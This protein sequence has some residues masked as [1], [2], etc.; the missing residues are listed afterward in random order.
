[1][2]LFRNNKDYPTK[3]ICT[4]RQEIP[5]EN[6]DTLFEVLKVQYRKLL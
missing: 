2:Q 6:S 4:M 1:M 5:T 3:F